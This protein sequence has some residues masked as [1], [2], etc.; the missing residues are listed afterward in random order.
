MSL[1][2]K[3][4]DHEFVETREILQLSQRLTFNI[5]NVALQIRHIGGI[6]IDQN[7]FILTMPKIS[8]VFKVPHYKNMLVEENMART[9][10]KYK[11]SQYNL[12][13]PLREP[14]FISGVHSSLWSSECPTMGSLK[15]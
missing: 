3:T 4:N 2:C 6:Q 15:Y 12:H 7:I 1:E 8:P 5:R 10:R 14:V 13:T 9:Y 11:V